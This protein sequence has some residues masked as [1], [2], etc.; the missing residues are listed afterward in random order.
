[1]KKR[2]PLHYA[3]L[4][5]LIESIQLL[6]SKGANIN[7]IDIHYLNILLLLLLFIKKILKYSRKFKKKNK[8]PFFYSEFNSNEIGEMLISN[9]E[10]SGNEFMND[11]GEDDLALKNLR[12]NGRKHRCKQNFG[13]KDYS[14]KRF[15]KK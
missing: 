8:T 6:I 5:N 1:M 9:A 7:S 4:N 10:I 13:K 11:P 14:F 2:T 12:N 15:S 3:A